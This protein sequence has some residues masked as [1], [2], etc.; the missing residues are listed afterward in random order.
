MTA[1]APSTMT[2]R[3][4]PAVRAAGGQ[5]WKP[6][7]V[8]AALVLAVLVPGIAEGG[9]W[10]RHP[11]TTVVNL[12]VSAG[13]I[14]AGALLAG[15]AE[16]RVTGYVLIASGVARPLRWAD[17]WVSGPGPLYSAVFGYLSI[18]L[19]AWALLRYPSSAMGRRRRRFMVVMTAWLI[20]VPAIQVCVGRPQWVGETNATSATWWPYL[21]PNSAVFDV[22]SNVLIAGC[23]LLAI[24]FLALMLWTVRVGGRR[25][26]AVRLPVAAAGMLAAV[27]SGVV[28]VITSVIGPH[29]EVFAIQGMAQL[30][31]P[32]AFLVSFAQQRLTRLSTLVSVLDNAEP[33]TRLLRQ[34]LRHNLRD[35][36]LDLLVWSDADKGYLTVDGAPPDAGPRPPNRRAIKVTGREG[37]PLALLVVDADAAGDDGLTDA[38]VAISKLALEN[39]MLSR[40][41]LT[42]DYDARQL[43]VAD[44]HDGAQKDL[45]ALRVALSK[46]G[47]AEPAQLPELL[48]TADKLV[49]NALQELRDLAHGVYPHT[50]THAGLAAAIEETADGLD[51]IVHL[52]APDHRLPATVEKT[53]YF[54]VSEALT[55]AHKHAGTIHLQVGIRQSGGVVTAEVLDDGTGGADGDGP[56]LGR[57]RDRIEA[58]GGRL[59]VSSPRGTGT[60]VVARIPC[61]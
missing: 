13:A 59:H 60:H 57:L 20:G 50:L 15:D 40:R 61:V 26:R 11:L 31:V 39:L 54:F 29:E 6:V 12:V 47:Y 19:T 51:L 2:G 8:Q 1:A 16:Q 49:S 18:V 46:V 5:R 43:L 44:L 34:L 41:L 53:V 30:G 45:C 4:R 56:G 10:V 17:E 35:P 52:T 23:A 28:V 21:W 25:E 38:A 33:T 55:N 22:V 37:R 58:H 9:L 14:G 48:D 42:A 3:S 32:I 7:A 24:G 36:N 27:V